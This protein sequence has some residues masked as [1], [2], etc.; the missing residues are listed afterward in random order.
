M[1]DLVTDRIVVIRQNIQFDSD[2]IRGLETDK[3]TAAGEALPEPD[4]SDNEAVVVTVDVP[5][6]EPAV[7][8]I[9][10]RAAETLAGKDAE[11][12]IE[13]PTSAISFDQEAMS[14]IAAVKATVILSVAVYDNEDQADWTKKGTAVVIDLVDDNGNSVLPDSKN[15]GTIT[16]KVPYT[17]TGSIQVYYRDEQGEYHWIPD[18]KRE[19]DYVVFT[20]NHLSDYVIVEGAG[21]TAWMENGALEY[22]VAL[23]QG[24]GAKL[25]IAWYDDVTGQMKGCYMVA[26]ES[27]RLTDIHSDCT[28]KVIL[29]S[30]TFAPLCPAVGMSAEG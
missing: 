17:G 18:A 22:R 20:T 12:T 16:I 15:N 14:C 26:A 2:T 28:Y 23:P 19:G 5:S 30:D 21:L 4:A 24:Q 10:D 11:I 29:V 6:G 7:I 1:F 8:V 25:L 13:T 3:L 9:P 27:G